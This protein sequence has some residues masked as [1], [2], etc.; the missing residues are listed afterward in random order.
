MMF[1]GSLFHPIFRLDKNKKWHAVV[2]TV[3]NFRFHKT[4]E[5]S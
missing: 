3:M 1:W 4:Q 2:N 5:I